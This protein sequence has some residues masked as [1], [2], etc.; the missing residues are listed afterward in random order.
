MATPE[1]FQQ[2]PNIKYAFKI[3]KSGRAIGCDIK[4]YFR[5]MT[6]RDDIFKKDTVYVDYEIK[7]YE[8]PDQISYELYGDEQYYWTILQTNNII[9]YY[10]QWPLDQVEFEEY[11]LRKYKTRKQMQETHHWETENIYEWETFKYEEVPEDWEGDDNE[12]FVRQERKKEARR[13]QKI[14]RVIV[15]PGG[16]HVPSDYSYPSYLNISNRPPV[17][18]TNWVY[19]S[20]KNEDKRH[21]Q[22]IQEQHIIDFVR[23]Y[24]NYG[25][26]LSDSMSSVSISDVRLF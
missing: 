3:D 8:R 9:D 12:W 1:Y 21:I 16:M 14:G 25:R 22:V 2:F 5:R 7:N 19:E 23:E 24:T 11:M 6:V 4:D 20:R 10:N 26:R 17:E 15:F 18:I 13:G